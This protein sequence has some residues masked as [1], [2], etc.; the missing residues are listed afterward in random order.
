MS[1]P[2]NTEAIIFIPASGDAKVKEGGKFVESSRDLE[3]LGTEGGYVK[4]KAGSGNY[5]FTTSK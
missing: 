2:V 3:Y 4:V 1:I 5:E